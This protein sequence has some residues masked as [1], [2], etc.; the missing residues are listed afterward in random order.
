MEY[1]QRLNHSAHSLLGYE[2]PNGFEYV[3]KIR[4]WQ[5]PYQPVRRIGSAPISLTIRRR[6][7]STIRH[8]DIVLRHRCSLPNPA[9]A[10]LHEAAFAVDEQI[11]T[12][13]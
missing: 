2:T 6:N 1:T 5:E 3:L 8:S 4:T 9:T 7:N 13:E 11:S 12:I 10:P